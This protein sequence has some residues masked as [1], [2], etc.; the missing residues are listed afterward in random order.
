VTM[1]CQKVK[2]DILGDS[3]TASRHLH[4]IEDM[5]SRLQELHNELKED[6]KEW[7]DD[8]QEEEYMKMEDYTGLLL[9][10]IGIIKDAIT[11]KE[12][13]HK[14]DSMEPPMTVRPSARLPKIELPHFSGNV[15]EWQGFYDCFVATVH[16]STISDVEKL[17]YL[18]GA[19]K[20]EPSNVISGLT[21]SNDNYGIAVEMLEKRYG[22]RRTV[23]RAHVRELLKIEPLRHLET[24]ELRAFRDKIELHVRS[25]EVLGIVKEEIDVFLTE[26]I[27]TR[28]PDSL[29]LEWGRLEEDPKSKLACS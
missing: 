28:V 16:K 18:R 4:K 29:R 12:M 20:G 8:E 6:M 21:L 11:E 15:L 9:D 24:K 7:Q 14:H 27:L 22:D 3:R 1:A 5:K 17:V 23:I 10:T 2:E 19:L 13:A 25:L 26:I